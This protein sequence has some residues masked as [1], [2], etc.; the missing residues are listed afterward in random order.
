VSPVRAAW[1]A[2]GARY[3]PPGPRAPHDLP[4]L[5]GRAGG[6]AGLPALAVAL[7]DG[8][9]VLGADA[10]KVPMKVAGSSR[11]VA[12]DSS[13]PAVLAR[14]AAPPREQTPHADCT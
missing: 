13:V 9:D 5:L 2:R 8:G 1:G 6:A 11:P 7:D 10:M 4:L 14:A 12:T 3:P